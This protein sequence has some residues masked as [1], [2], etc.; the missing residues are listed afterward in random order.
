MRAHQSWSRLMQSMLD[1]VF[2]I[3]YQLSGIRLR[4]ILGR[5]KTFGGGVTKKKKKRQCI[6]N[7]FLGNDQNQNTAQ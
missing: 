1:V 4:L 2:G 7:S 3:S 6:G 5:E